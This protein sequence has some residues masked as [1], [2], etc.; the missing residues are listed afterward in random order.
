MYDLFYVKEV[1]KRKKSPSSEVALQD[2]KRNIKSHAKTSVRGSKDKTVFCFI[3]TVLI[4]LLNFAVTYIVYLE[5]FKFSVG[6][7]RLF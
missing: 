3:S 7:C 2:E 1:N 4:M 5:I 6:Y